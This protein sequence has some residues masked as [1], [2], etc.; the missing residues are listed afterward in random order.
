MTDPSDRMTK[1]LAALATRNPALSRLVEF[2]SADPMT[3]L[4]TL[5]E[6]MAQA[7]QATAPSIS[8]RRCPHCGLLDIRETHV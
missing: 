8:I 1:A 5:L 7:P 2:G 6:S 4:A 3:M